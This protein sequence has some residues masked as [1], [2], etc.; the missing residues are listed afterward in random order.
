MKKKILVTGCAGYIGSELTRQLL[1]DDYLVAG[2]DSLKFGNDSIVGIMD[3]P[4]FIFHQLDLRDTNKVEK[5][6]KDIYGVVHLAAIVGDP[7]CSK[8]PQ[9]A[10]EVNWIAA[11]SL[12]NLCEKTS[13][14]KRFIF[15]STCSNYGKM[16]GEKYLNE[17]SDLRPVSLYAKLKV[18]FEKYLLQSKT[19]DD[20]YP[21]ALRFSTAYGLSPRI[22]FDL[23]VNEFIRDATMKKRLI[24]YGE[25]FWRPYCHVKDL[26][27]ACKLVL[28]SEV[29]KID[30]NVFGIGDTNENYQKK[31]I[32][33]EILKII[34]ETKVTYIT[35]KE[36]PRDYRV[37]FSKIKNELKFNISEK[38]TDGLAEIH[39]LLLSKTIAN[40][41]SQTYTNV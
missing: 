30:H 1:D 18:M 27:R 21:T 28:E 33:E 25:Y 34:P 22:R 11:K 24:I 16:N 6:L 4:N 13:S 32:A 10:F 36:D 20:F 39:S 8:N 17:D 9:E 19:R 3:N 31:M 15:A 23:T 2:V 40:P 29:G 12:F 7:A 14:I 41:F 37:D 5:I 26:A 38:L 35:R